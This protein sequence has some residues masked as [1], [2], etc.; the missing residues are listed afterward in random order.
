MKIVY[1]LVGASGNGSEIMPLMIG[2][3]MKDKRP[4]DDIEFF[5]I[6]SNEKIETLN[7]TKV[8]T[9]DEFFSLKTD[10]SFFNISISDSKI[11]ADIAQ[12]FEHK[13]STALDIRADSSQILH[14]CEVGRGSILASN[15]LLTSNITVG[16][17]FQ[18][19][20][21]SSIAHDCI[22]GDFVTLAPGARVNG[23]V[24]IDDHAYIGSE[25][26]IKQGTPEKPLVIGKGSF[27]GMGA[28]VTKD[29]LP[30]TTVIGNPA[31][32]MEK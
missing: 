14:N 28:V 29:V 8:I 19:N 16:K 25:A 24:R 26:V 13:G 21:Y 27:I 12:R 22:I 5:F 3:V 17:F 4:S 2:N 11:R 15:S 18:S 6:D 1:G 9:E 30:N 23:N 31:K 32:L 20:I 10:K 7:S